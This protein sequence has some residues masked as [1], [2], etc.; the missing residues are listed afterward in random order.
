[1]LV[2]TQSKGHKIIGLQVGV[3]NVRRYFPKGIQVIELEL[4]HLQIQCQL[5]PEFWL[6][7]PEIQDARLGA[8]LK[9]KNFHQTPHCGPVPLAL[10]PNGKSSYRL[11][12]IGMKRRRH[13]QPAPS[14]FNAA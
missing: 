3:N 13:R 5:G 2:R 11:R 9:S 10:I 1:M 4:D 14:P 6:G 7:E 8:W 12:P